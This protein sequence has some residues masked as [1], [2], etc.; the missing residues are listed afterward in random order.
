MVKN[1][2]RNAIA[3]GV[4]VDRPRRKGTAPAAM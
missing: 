4:I 2:A 1:L 3:I